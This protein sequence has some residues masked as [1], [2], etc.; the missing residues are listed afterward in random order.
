MARWTG[1]AGDSPSTPSCPAPAFR[2]SLKHFFANFAVLH[3]RIRG[4]GAFLTPR[5]GIGFFRIPNLGSR[6]PN[7]YFWELSDNFLPRL[8]R[9]AQFQP[10]GFSQ[11]F[12]FFLQIFLHINKVLLDILPSVLELQTSGFSNVF[13]LILHTNKVIFRNFANCS[14]TQISFSF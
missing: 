3:I 6:N 8:P 9:Y 5:S 10:S 13:L 14:K 4:S 12:C 1:G 2:F 7:P 11:T